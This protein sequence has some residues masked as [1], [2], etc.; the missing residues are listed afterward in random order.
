MEPFDQADQLCSPQDLDARVALM[1]QRIKNAP[2]TGVLW[3]QLGFTL[4]VKDIRYH[5]SGMSQKEALFA[6]K[7]AV[8]LLGP[9]S[10]FVSTSM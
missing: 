3:A 8:K 2:L 7:M 10:Q 9:C 4:Q 5:D 1:K 6:Y